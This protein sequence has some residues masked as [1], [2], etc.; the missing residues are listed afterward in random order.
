MALVEGDAQLEILRCRREQIQGEREVPCECSGIGS[1]TTL[2]SDVQELLDH[3]D[4][5]AG[6]HDAVRVGCQQASARLA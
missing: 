3:L 6:V 2:R 5:G 4:R 1:Q